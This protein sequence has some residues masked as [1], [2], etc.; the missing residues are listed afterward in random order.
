[1]TKR[2]RRGIE[3]RVRRLQTHLRQAR[4]SI[5]IVKETFTSPIVGCEVGVFRG[6]HSEQMLKT[7]SNLTRLYLVDPYTLYEG[8]TD[9]ENPSTELLRNA[10]KE[11]HQRLEPF[12]DRVIWIRDKFKANQIHEPLDFI[13]IDGQHTYE[14]VANDTVSYTHLTPVSYTHLTLPT[15]PYV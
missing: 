2:L 9:F 15:T 1:M 11:A 10:E 3:R 6:K 4:P 5:Q 13:Y 12:K 8:Y 7:L 14:A